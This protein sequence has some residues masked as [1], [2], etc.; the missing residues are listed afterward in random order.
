MTIHHINSEFIVGPGRPVWSLVTKLVLK[1]SGGLFQWLRRQLFLSGLTIRSNSLTSNCF[2]IEG[3]KST[4]NDSRYL[5]RYSEQL[6]DCI[7]R[8]RGQLYNFPDP[9]NISLIRS[10]ARFSAPSSLQNNAPSHILV[11]HFSSALESL[12]CAM[13]AAKRQRPLNGSPR[14]CEL[15]DGRGAIPEAKCRPFPN[16]DTIECSDCNSE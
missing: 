10:Q 11:S 13:P 6:E 15:P 7:C 3:C 12:E 14:S 4:N 9:Y 1:A 8:V 5:F 16:G 2:P